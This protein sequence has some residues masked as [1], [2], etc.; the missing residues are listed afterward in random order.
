MPKYDIDVKLIGENGNVF[1]LMSKCTLAMKRHGVD[2][3]E[4]EKFKDECRESDYD[5]AL[6]TMMKW[7][8]VQ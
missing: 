2:S 5:H 8:N 7:V 4:I 6:R 1:N 3:E